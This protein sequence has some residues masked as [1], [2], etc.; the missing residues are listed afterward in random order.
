MIYL[1]LFET[2]SDYEAAKSKLLMPNVS[3]CEHEDEVHFKPWYET[4]VVAKFNVTDTSNPTM[5]ASGTSGFS[6][7]E[8]DGVEQ[9]SVTTGYTF[10]TTGGHTVKYTLKGK[11]IG[12]RAFRGCIRL[13][14][15]QIPNDITYIGGTAFYGCHGLKSLDIPNSVTSVSTQVFS[16][17]SGL[18]S[19]TIG[20]GLTAIKYGFLQS[21][22]ALKS[23][24]IPS[25][26]TSIGDYAFIN[27]YSLTS[28]RCNPTSPPTLGTDV[29]KNTN[30]C[31]I[32]VP[33]GSVEAYKSASGWSEYAS[34]IQAI[35]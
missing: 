23:I 26:V 21:C 31:P 29:F 9:P 14:D 27:C 30:N 8:I 34:R 28:V 10:S 4:R 22:S 25:G 35:P 12:D 19:C 16:Y 6:I 15:I 11:S 24:N 18:I 32:Y 1:T 13:I 3:Y 20:S 7:I 2:H 5:I 33:S 17:C